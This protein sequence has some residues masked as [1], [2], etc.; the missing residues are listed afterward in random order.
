MSGQAYLLAHQLEEAFESRRG[1]FQTKSFALVHRFDVEFQ[2]IQDPTEGFLDLGYR[3][4][5][6]KF[7]FERR[8]DRSG[9][10]SLVAVKFPFAVDAR[11]RLDR[12]PDDIQEPV[13]V[14]SS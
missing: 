5:V 10:P 6:F 11:P 12:Q 2:M 7:E 3:N 14:T 4:F 1:T 13:R 8:P 9:K